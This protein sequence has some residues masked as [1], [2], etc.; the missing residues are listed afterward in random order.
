MALVLVMVVLHADVAVML[1]MIA[2][3]S[4]DGDS[5]E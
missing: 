5:G 2:V 1:V 4:I 3:V